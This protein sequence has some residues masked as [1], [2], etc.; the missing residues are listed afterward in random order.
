[1]LR[2]SP[3]LSVHR[4]R[5]HYW[6]PASHAA[7]HRVQQDLDATLIRDVGPALAAAGSAL[8]DQSGEVVFVRRL[9][10][11]YA[12]DAAW[13][14]DAIARVTAGAFTRSLCRVLSEPDS[15]N[16]VR[17]RSAADYLAA[18]V[19][20]RAA[21]TAAL[22][23]FFSTFEGWSALSASAAIRSAL[24]DDLETGRAALTSL[25]STA[26]A[27]LVEALTDGDARQLVDVLAPAAANGAH[28]FADVLTLARELASAPPPAP[29]LRCA[30]LGVWLLATRTRPV[31]AWPIHTAVLIMR[32]LDEAAGRPGMPPFDRLLAMA[33]E[34]Q[35]T[36]ARVAVLATNGRREHV[37]R[38]AR[39]LVR[40]SAT[41]A[42]S[43]PEVMRRSTRFGGLFLLL[44][45]LLEIDLDHATAGWPTLRGTPAL[46][47]VR[48][49]VLALSAGGPGGGDAIVSDP[50]WRDTFSWS[51]EIDAEAVT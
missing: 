7:P 28:V 5:N 1:M 43:V 13:G 22:P 3:H 49:A 45:D 15:E 27:D 51:P 21:G 44:G 32:V 18:Y 31:S 12:L 4:W 47:I 10:L 17:F 8:L 29:L 30:G 14:R 20:A 23:W 42:S 38:F 50:Y 36:L 34:D 37:E 46:S 19:A 35:H 2:T 11:D 9:D 40:R 39:A 41:P 48:L 25:G 6:I 24:A 26:L 16:V 33:A